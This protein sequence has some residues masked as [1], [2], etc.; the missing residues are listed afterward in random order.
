MHTHLINAQCL[1]RDN[2]YRSY[3]CLVK[4]DIH[5]RVLKMKTCRWYN[6]TVATFLLKV[7]SRH[8]FN[9]RRTCYEV[10][11]VLVKCLWKHCFA[12]IVTLTDLSS[13]C[14]E[15]QNEAGSWHDYH[16]N[17]P[18]WKSCKSRLFN[19]HYHRLWYNCI[20]LILLSKSTD[21]AILAVLSV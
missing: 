9:Q 21:T 14:L 6:V 15:S 17:L 7:K 1:D 12:Q 13:R 11:A 16:E 2:S 8:V 3:E 10:H 4:A 18:K 19:T 5:A 20:H